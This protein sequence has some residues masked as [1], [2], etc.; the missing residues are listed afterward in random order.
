MNKY[1]WR[2]NDKELYLPK[3]KPAIIN[4]PKLN[5]FM[6]DGCGNPNTEEFSNAIGAIYSLTYAV[7]MGLKKHKDYYEYTVFPLEGIWDLAVEA[8]GLD[9]LDKDKL[10]Y[11][12]MIRQPD[13]LT[14]ELAKEVIEM[15]KI[16]K[17]NVL[18]NKIK[19]SSL[20]EGK[21]LQ[22][23][24]IGSYDDEPQSFKIMEDF[25]KNNNLKR[26]SK[27]HKEIYI[28]DFRRT[29]PSKLKTVLRFKVE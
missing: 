20:D 29:E 15:Q 16:K 8:R 6:L 3:T 17:P 25:C 1:E 5:Y 21:C 13:F 11:T 9:Y 4:V 26:L 2:K 27:I 23:M 18:F 12:L 10:V 28:S 22:M 19:F 24:H 14:N 7:K